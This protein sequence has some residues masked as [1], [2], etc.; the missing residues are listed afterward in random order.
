MTD[1]LDRGGSGQIAPWGVD[2]GSGSA[3]P[4]LD[5]VETVPAPQFDLALPVRVVVATLAGV[6]SLLCFSLVAAHVSGAPLQGV[7]LVVVAWMLLAVA[8]VVLARP[9]RHVV[10]RSMAVNAVVAVAFVINHTVMWPGTPRDGGVTVAGWAVFAVAL[11]SIIAG[12]VALVRPR[13]GANWGHEALVLASMAPVGVLVLAT[14]AIA[15]PVANHGA[16]A[17]TVEV[18]AAGPAVSTTIPV[19]STTVKGT[20]LA[21]GESIETAPDVP[22]DAATQTLLGRQL[23][24]AR[25]AES[26]FPTAGDAKKA[27]MMLA[28]G[29]APGVGAHYQT[30]SAAALRGIE[31]DGTVDPSA[32]SSYIYQ[33]TTD[34]APIVGLM[35]TAFGDTA[36]EGFAGPNDHWHRHSNVCLKFA[37]GKIDVPVAP[38]QDVTK[39]Q[40]DSLGGKFMAKTVWMV[41][42]WVV[43]GWE[44]PR[45][46]FSH[47]NPNL[48]CPDGVQADGTD[49]VDSL[50]ICLR[51]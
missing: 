28:G 29:A 51:Q 26:K 39:Q 6:G 49:R 15:A 43:P 40:C 14:A 2:V 25:A 32:P 45:G 37:D 31:A 4:A 17:S 7:A 38:D 18:I 24:E 23:T 13:L 27:G 5:I 46:V 44:S 21:E 20:A 35:Y 50:G 19:T 34:D 30:M 41:H 47:A 9:S 42:A 12:A 36:P 48:H 11:L 8:V 10:H 16:G 1:V 22:L 33:G 3:E